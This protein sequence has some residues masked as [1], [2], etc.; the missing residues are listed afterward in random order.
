MKITKINHLIIRIINTKKVK[1]LK[2]FIKVKNN[3]PN[4][5]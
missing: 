5:N 3:Y 2:N 1:L 4:F